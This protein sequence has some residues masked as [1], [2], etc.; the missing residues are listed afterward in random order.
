MRWVATAG[1]VLAILVYAGDART[2]TAAA[3][4]GP[5]TACPPGDPLTPGNWLQE[6]QNAP[7]SPAFWDVVATCLMTTQY[8]TL[9]IDKTDVRIGDTLT[10]TLRLADGLPWCSATLPRQRPCVDGFEGFLVAFGTSGRYRVAGDRDYACDGFNCDPVL[11]YIPGG[12]N[13]TWPSFTRSATC[14]VAVERRSYPPETQA[15]PLPTGWYV[16]Q[17]DIDVDLN[18]DPLSPAFIG[19]RIP[20]DAAFS[21]HGDAPAPETGT[22]VVIEETDPPAA[23]QAFSFTGSGAIG[24][25]SLD[26]DPASATPDRR[27]FPDLAA[28]NHT[29]TETMPDGWRLAAITC[30]DPSGG[31]TTDRASATATIDLTAGETVTCTFRNGERGAL[32][33][34][35][36]EGGDDTDPGDGVCDTGDTITRNGA[37]EP[38]CTLDAAFRE[39]NAA[40]GKDTILFDVPGTNVPVFYS[41]QTATGPVVV[42]GTSQPGAGRVVL[43]GVAADAPGFDPQYHRGHGLVLAGGNSEVRGLVLY[44]WPEYALVLR[45]DGNVV[46]GNWIGLT[47]TGNPGGNGLTVDATLPGGE[48]VEPGGGGILVESSHNVIGGPGS[49]PGACDGACNRIGGN[50]WLTPRGGTPDQDGGLGVAIMDTA[51]GNVV[52][53]NVFE[54][55]GGSGIFVSGTGNRIGGPSAGQANVFTGNRTEDSID[56]RGTRNEIEGNTIGFDP[57]SGGISIGGTGGIRV[58]DASSAIIRGNTIGA[59]ASGIELFLSNDTLIERNAIG[60]TTDGSP[61][62]NRGDGIRVGLRASGTTIAR[63]VIAHNQRAG[64][65]IE[66]EAGCC[67]RIAANDIHD[68]DGLGIDIGL[69]GVTP[70]DL[71]DLDGL[72]NHPTLEHVGR[73]GTGVRVQGWLEATPGRYTIELY[74]VAACDPSGHGEGDRPAGTFDIT[75]PFFEFEVPDVTSAYFSA[76]ATDE[77]GNTSEFSACTPVSTGAELTAPSPS[78]STRLEVSSS[79]GLVGKVVAIGEGATA[80][81]NY[82]EASGSLLLARPTRFAHAAGETVVPRDDTLF[83]SL[84][85][86]L[87]TRAARTPDSAVLAGR[88]RPVAGRT[89]ACGDDVT[90]TLDGNVVAQRIPGARFTRQAG[91]RCVFA[92]RTENGIARL[93]LDLGKGTWNAEVIRRDLEKLTN[94]VDVGLAVGDDAGSETLAFRQRGNVWTYA[95]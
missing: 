40:E 24:A 28:G 74:T 64:V 21:F 59:T 43:R 67:N 86:A 53:G 1:A 77:R 17:G 36:T 72:R 78:G 50:A 82:G 4:T 35:S 11:R 6:Y 32:V 81:T 63:N 57:A 95:R 83:V 91:N 3:Q 5:P 16:V 26:T 18:P 55:N 7:L 68:N 76:T 87:I 25:F 8:A 61:L 73:R 20:A 23:A 39:A 66:S 52:V 12:D 60:A 2:P 93:E 13:C 9:E 41:R 56:V 84:D 29:I 30:A 48:G 54:D 79:E 46:E 71:G 62:P 94:P 42:D 70:N 89:I 22:I 10:L 85:R 92:T 69:A 37:D 15:P 34:N 38:E 90:L 51:A 80:E 33:V 49:S 45:G 44:G 14:T 47:E 88:L 31:T 58:Q 75:T 19:G 27:T 65:R